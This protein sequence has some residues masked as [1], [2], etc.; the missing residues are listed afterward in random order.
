MR[1]MVGGYEKKEK[2]VANTAHG[3]PSCGI[4]R[5]LDLEQ[6]GSVSQKRRSG[7]YKLRGRRREKGS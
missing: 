5:G 2:S 1:E 4:T 3:T 6:M 7:I